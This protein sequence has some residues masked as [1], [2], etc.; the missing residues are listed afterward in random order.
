MYVA[1]IYISYLKQLLPQKLHFK[2]AI[3]GTHFKITSSKNVFQNYYP[4][5]I[6][7][8][9]TRTKWSIFFSSVYSREL[10]NLCSKL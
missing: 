8:K 6:V 5:S 10:K 7:I 1:I 4:S 2:T 9:G 3:S